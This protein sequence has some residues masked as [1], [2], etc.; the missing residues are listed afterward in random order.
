[1]LVTSDTPQL[2]VRRISQHLGVKEWSIA[3]ELKLGAQGHQGRLVGSKSIGVGL[4]GQG[5][6]WRVAL[7][8]YLDWLGVNEED[9]LVCGDDGL[10]QIH[11]FEAVAN[12]EKLT[13]KQLV[14]FVQAN[15]L[16]HLKYGKSFYF[17]HRQRVRAE[18]LHRAKRPA[19]R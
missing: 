1:M 18:T 10:P 17:T 3:R 13:P 19:L 16:E 7:D 15:G 4:V 6:Q 2:T 12:H 11:R 8:N 14:E 9:R 5:G